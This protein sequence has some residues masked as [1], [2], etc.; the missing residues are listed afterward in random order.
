MNSFSHCFV[1]HI[2]LILSLRIVCIATSKLGWNLGVILNMNNTDYHLKVKNLNK[3]IFTLQD[4]TDKE[5]VRLN[6]N[7]DWRYAKAEYEIEVLLINE[8]FTPEILLF[9][10][11]NCNYFLALSGNGSNTEGI[12]AAIV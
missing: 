10:I 7:M 8:L 5:L 1:A 12:L 2:G 11:H 6:I 9:L 3:G 4:A